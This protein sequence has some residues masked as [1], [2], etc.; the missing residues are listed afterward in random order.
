MLLTA[1]DWPRP[2]DPDR[3]RLGRERWRERAG[4]LGEEIASFAAGLED[5]PEGRRM[6]DAIFG[7]SPFLTEAILKEPSFLNALIEGPVADQV[8]TAIAE[9]E[10]LGAESD[11]AKLMA[12]LRRGKRR[13]A[14][15]AALADIGGLWSLEE[16][17]GALSRFAESA[18]G[19]A[20]RHLLRDAANRGAIDLA[21]AHAPERGSGLIVLG[22]GKL[23]G[24][25]L[26]YSS[27]ID[28][29]IFYDDARVRT[30]RPDDMAHTF[31]RLARDL[32]RIMEERTAEGYVFRT[33]LRLRPD[34]GATPP[35]V[36]VSAA[37]VYYAAMAQNWERAAMIKAR[38]LAGDREAGRDFLKMMVP[39]V[40]RRNLDFAAIRD[41]HAIKRQ[42]HAHK[43]HAAIALK[44]H[45]IKLG[46]GG[47]REIEF[48]AQTQQLIFGGRN[49]RLR[50]PATCACLEALAEEG[51]VDRATVDDL[52]EAYGFLRR[53]EHRLQM[54]DDQ[55]THSLPETDEG[56]DAIGAFMGFRDGDAFRRRLRE[57]LE[58]VERHYAELFEETPDLAGPPGL[59]LAGS[60]DDP[61]T[62]AALSAMGFADPVAVLGLVRGWLHGRYRAVRSERAR[63]L[64]REL[65]PTLLAALAR[66]PNPDTALLRLDTFLSR[67]PAGI[68]LFS[69]FHANP[70]LLDLVAELLGTSNRLADYLSRNPDLLEAVLTPGFLRTLDEMPVL[71]R[72]LG[73]LIAAAL[74]YEDLLNSLRR[75]TNDQRFRAGVH[76]LRRVSDAPEAT[77]YLSD[78]AEVALRALAPKVEAEFAR[79]HGGFGKP[80]LAIM[81]MGKLGGREMSI[82]SDLDLIM[83]YD[84]G[85]LPPE[86]D[87]DKPLAPTVYFARLIHRII[88]A[89]TA[90]TAEGALY[91]VDMR[92]RPSGNAGPVAT[93][94]EAF[95][96]YHDES[97]WT[98][99]H[100]A[101][102]R[103]RII[104]GPPELTATL[105]GLIRGVLTRRRDPDTLLR[106]VADM[107][108]RIGKQFPD[109]P[110]WEV[111]HTRGGMVD[112][113]F[114]AQYLQLREAANHPDIL[115]PN[116]ATALGRLAEAGILEEEA[117]EDLKR[118]LLLLQ[119]A[120]LFLRLTVEGAFDPATAPDALK[121]ALARSVLRDETETPDFETVAAMLA[122]ALDRAHGHFRR[123]IEEPAVAGA[124]G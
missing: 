3:A 109:R 97:A 124:A 48:F 111:K 37:E 23:G 32:V 50:V 52:I 33:D 117:A 40:W 15:A 120:Q 20:T 62:M 57:T 100:M 105:E 19:A 2:A 9:T 75:W 64:M 49:P 6:L 89:I 5:A 8:E 53:V 24:G 35:A 118:A 99:E 76:V 88:A 60:D 41:I 83:V 104:A 17:T 63:N 47:I 36:S 28:L 74:H 82:R 29:I 25:E 22:M 59:N 86:S 27:D 122:A 77:A 123:L 92:L 69:M 65:A 84:S 61:D 14:T 51:R 112:I 116:T 73:D 114:I 72:D 56:L 16:V 108:R 42:I 45:N 95:T 44:G 58:C 81:A 103:A 21:D 26:N 80:E 70:G 55:Q 66:T 54:I 78:V 71:E 7:N 10:G 11:R 43:G 13:V 94:L 93:A 102:T 39:F 79:R 96:R 113:E 34:P 121:Q 91:D 4:S 110:I 12:G 18:L 115:S 67:L 87:G 119:R 107:R 90:P 30:S 38:P 106:D 68:Q 98:W 31:I 101:L 46:R 85:G 1:P